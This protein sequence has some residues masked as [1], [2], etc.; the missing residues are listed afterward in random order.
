MKPVLVVLVAAAVMV[1]ST[2]GGAQSRVVETET[3][4]IRIETVASGLAHP[5]AMA[6]LPD[7]RML[8]TER[9]GTLRIVDTEFS[10]SEPLSG[11]PEVFAERQGG[12]LDVAVDPDFESN[13]RV[14]LTYAEPGDGGASTA[15]ARGVLGEEGLDDVEVIFR[16]EPKLGG[17][18]HFG[19]RLVF[20]GDGTLFVTLGDRR[21]DELS[22]DLLNHIGTIVRINPDGS[23]PDDNPFVADDTARPEIWSYGHRNAQGAA[24]NPE[25]GELW[26]HEHG[27]RG[28]DELNIARAGENHGWPLVS[29]GNHYD[30][31]PIPDPPTRPQFAD[32]I[33]YWVPAIAPSGMSFYTGELFPDWHGNL[34]LG[35]LV[36][37]A[38]VRLSLDGNEV[39]GEERI[40]LGARVRD[41]RQ[42]P[43]GAVYVVTDEPDGRILRLAPDN[44]QD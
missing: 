31:R 23:V 1:N 41:V 33:H 29:W 38:V 2:P 8:V 39:I 26:A 19:S 40:G 9:P 4:S 13:R 16:Q 10:L 25:T 36:A 12:L 24:L 42:G 15:A 5:W 3:G 43:D 17:G 27:P 21:Q 18:A 32:A 11:V 14:Y 34:L 6:F 37:Q 20:H 35:G 7:G 28:G 30:G 44:K 22:Q